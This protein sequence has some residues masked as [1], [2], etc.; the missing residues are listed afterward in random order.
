[1]ERDGEL[2]ERLHEGRWSG[3]I[4]RIPHRGMHART[5]SHLRVSR[6]AVCT[7]LVAHAGG[8]LSG[9]RATATEREFALPSTPWATE[10]W[11]SG[12]TNASAHQWK[13]ATFH[14][15]STR[16]SRNHEALFGNHVGAAL[17][18]AREAGGR[19][20]RGFY[21]IRV[22]VLVAMVP[23]QGRPGPRRVP[24]LLGS[25]TLRIAHPGEAVPPLNGGAWLAEI[26][27]LSP[28]V[29]SSLRHGFDYHTGADLPSPRR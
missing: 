4:G 15:S 12:S 8:S 1:M 7:P 21:G 26:R 18:S 11:D 22:L 17:P 24:F 2:Y 13:P 23:R 10:R 20:A 3:R 5:V 19:F 9:H 6:R 25:R 29:Q 27:Y 14:R 16:R 28:A